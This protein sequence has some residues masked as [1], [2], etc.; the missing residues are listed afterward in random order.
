MKHFLTRR[1]VYYILALLILLIVINVFFFSCSKKNGDTVEISV[2]G[3]IV[4]SENLA[5]NASV[6]IIKD[7]VETN[8]VVIS[9]GVVYMKEANCK[10]KLCIK[11]GKK[12]IG[13]ESIV[14]L[15][16]RVVV[17]IKSSNYE[18]DSIAE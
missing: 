16:N 8:L 17:T 10:D 4:Y 3:E 11:Q 6:P 12:S 14:C 18:F 1:D 15:P 13:N 9:D 5:V 2:D 7:G